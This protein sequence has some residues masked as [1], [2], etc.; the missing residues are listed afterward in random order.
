MVTP[1]NLNVV[2]FIILGLVLVEKCDLIWSIS[3]GIFASLAKQLWMMLHIGNPYLFLVSFVV[4]F[5]FI[6]IT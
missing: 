3:D 2:Y 5:I 4:R 1:K 6:F